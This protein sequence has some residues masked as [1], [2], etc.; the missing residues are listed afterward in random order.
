[1]VYP[2]KNYSNIQVSKTRRPNIYKD[3]IRAIY[4]T[5]SPLLEL[6]NLAFSTDDEQLKFACHR[7]LAK[8]YAPQLKA[9][10]HEGDAARPI[11]MLINLDGKTHQRLNDAVNDITT[12][13]NAID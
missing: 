11:N 13:A 1:M 4:E 8:Y 5:Y 3:E 12:E 7:E 10:T 2:P 9:V 6:K